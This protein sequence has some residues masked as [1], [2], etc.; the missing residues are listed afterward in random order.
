MKG[1]VKLNSDGS[2]S[3]SMSAGC[4]SVIRG[5]DGEWFGGFAKNVGK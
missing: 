1:W 5:S 4:A 3:D 2:C